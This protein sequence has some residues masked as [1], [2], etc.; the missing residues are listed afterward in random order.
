MFRQIRYLKSRDLRFLGFVAATGLSIV[1]YLGVGLRLADQEG[2]GW[3]RLDL[4]A[5]LQRI[6]VGELDDREADWYHRAT[7]EEARGA[8]GATP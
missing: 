6:E 5:L 2:S 7:E 4:D 8:R 1:L 3:R